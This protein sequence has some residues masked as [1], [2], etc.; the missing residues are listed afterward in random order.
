MVVEGEYSASLD[1]VTLGGDRVVAIKCPVKGRDS[2]LWRAVEAGRLP[3]HY[4]WQV[5][6]QLMVTQ[7]KVAD[8]FVFDGGEGILFPVAPDTSTWPRIHAAWDQFMDFIN[9]KSPPPLGDRDTRLR[10]DPEWLSAAAAYLELRMEHEKLSLSVTRLWKRG[11]V[12]YK[13]VPALEGVDLEVYRGRGGKRS[14]HAYP[15]IVFVQAA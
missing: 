2:S 15:M 10:D 1:G 13:R 9:T 11:N 6:H 8:V 12:E 14:R 5:Q 3:E 4:A 7:A